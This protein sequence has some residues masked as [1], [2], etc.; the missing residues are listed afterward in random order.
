M[1]RNIVCRCYS[2]FA[3]IV[4]ATAAAAQAPVD[5]AAKSMTS[6]TTKGEWHWLIEPYLMLANMNGNMGLGS[7]PEVNVDANPHDIFSHVKVGA[8]A[9]AEARSQHWI[10]SSDLTYMRLGE[11][12]SKDNGV[13][14]GHA[15]AKQLG[16]ELA[17]L[18]R[19]KPWLAIG[20]AGQLNDLKS[21]LT[22]SV[23]DGTTTNAQ[24]SSFR[25][26]WVDP[27]FVAAAAMPLKGKWA[28][29]V[30]GNI[31][32]FGIA[33]KIYWQTQAYIDFHLNKLIQFSA[34]YRAIK[35]D[36]E[37]G[38]G[39]DYFLYNITTFGPVFRF[40]LNF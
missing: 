24:S 20:L 8:M 4:M 35:V 5:S 14:A 36:Y 21:E 40:G 39:S 1:K 30:R 34:G 23:N 10:L 26:T 9:Y 31:G 25:K 11:D 27:S 2:L 22:V 29:R 32:G 37:K 38:S 13:V 6:S 15:D 16:W 19:W 18:W 17:A 3:V 33:S 28:L 12:V 7:L